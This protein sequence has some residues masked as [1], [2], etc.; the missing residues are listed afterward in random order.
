MVNLFDL[1]KATNAQMSG[2]RAG[3]LFLRLQIPLGGATLL[4]VKEM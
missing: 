1:G 2:T 3:E 4:F